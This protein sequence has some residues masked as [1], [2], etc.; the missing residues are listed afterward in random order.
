[1]LLEV[2]ALSMTYRHPHSLNLHLVFMFGGTALRSTCCYS[3][4]STARQK[5]N[6]V[7]FTNSWMEA[8]TKIHIMCTVLEVVELNVTELSSTLYL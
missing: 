5:L 7:W 6:A 2:K 3:P 1:M 4:S 8:V